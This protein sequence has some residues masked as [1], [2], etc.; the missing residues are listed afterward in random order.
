MLSP[1]LNADAPPLSA[2]TPKS[3]MLGWAPLGGDT[4]MF[5]PAAVC[6]AVTWTMEGVLGAGAGLLPPV[7]MVGAGDGD[8]GGELE[9]APHP[10]SAAAA[11][12]TRRF[13][14]TGPATPAVVKMKTTNPGVAPR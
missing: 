1:V 14:Y 9:V 5:T 7:G 2:A 3:S 11:S 6:P 8:A 10:I 4:L 13:R 12:K